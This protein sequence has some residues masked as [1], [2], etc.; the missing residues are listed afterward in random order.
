M[1]RVEPETGRK[2]QI[3]VHAEW[4]DHCV[5]GDKIYGPD[6]RLYLEFIEQGLDRAPGGG[7]ADPASGLALLPVRLCVPGERSP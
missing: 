3:R 2:H 4:L 6:E 5:V 1:A 7:T